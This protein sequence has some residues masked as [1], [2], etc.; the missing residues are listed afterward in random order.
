MYCTVLYS[1]Q[2]SICNNRIKTKRTA[3]RVA[4]ASSRSGANSAARGEHGQRQRRRLRMRAQTASHVA[5]LEHVHKLLVTA[6]KRVLH[7]R[8][9]V[10]D[11]LLVLPSRVHLRVSKIINTRIQYLYSVIQYV[12]IRECEK[13]DSVS[14]H[15]DSSSERLRKRLRL[16][17]WRPREMR[18][19]PAAG[20]GLVDSS[21]LNLCSG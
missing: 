19:A 17:A 5:R 12:L 11:A 14:A 1:K 21:H 6:R 15:N 9:L 20:A 10:T 8:P 18:L 2:D 16:A 13:Q 4:A 7:R 3:T